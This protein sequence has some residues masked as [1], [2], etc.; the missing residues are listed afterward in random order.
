MEAYSVATAAD[1]DLD[2]LAERLHRA[3]VSGDHC[4]FMPRLVGAWARVG[5][6]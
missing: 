6:G 5:E 4:I 3:A 2:T 1:V